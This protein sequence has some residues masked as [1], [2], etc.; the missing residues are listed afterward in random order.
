MDT[1]TAVA[2]SFVGSC[3]PNTPVIS[4]GL[5]LK[6]SRVFL[7]GRQRKSIAF[8]TGWLKSESWKHGHGG[9]NSKFNRNQGGS[10]KFS[11]H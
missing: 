6:S 11:P 9:R 1:T 3:S 7:P 8:S 4:Q 5:F 10:V 2:T